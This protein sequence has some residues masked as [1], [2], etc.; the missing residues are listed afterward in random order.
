MKEQDFIRGIE[1]QMA[2]VNLWMENLSK[3]KKNNH[4]FSSNNRVTPS[5]VRHFLVKVTAG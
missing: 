5:I 2:P 4:R 1:D 3:E